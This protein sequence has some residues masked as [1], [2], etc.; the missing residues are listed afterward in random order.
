MHR[1]INS[2]NPRINFLFSLKIACNVFSNLPVNRVLGGEAVMPNEFP[3]MVLYFTYFI[4]LMSS[5]PEDKAKGFF[6]IFI[7]A[8]LVYLKHMES[9]YKVSFS[10]GGTIISEFFVLTAAH[11]VVGNYRPSSVR[12]GKVSNHHHIKAKF[13][14][15]H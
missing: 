2:N 14:T 5:Y 10:C 1:N 7:K 6:F 13:A 12:L 3:W 11:C 4:I 15:A 8:S 9:N